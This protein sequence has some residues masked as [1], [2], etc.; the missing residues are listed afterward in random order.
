MSSTPSE[1]LKNTFGYPSFRPGQSDIIKTILNK[2]NILAIMPTGAGKS[3]CYQ[4]PAIINKKKTIVV[5]P[6][7]ALMDDQVNSLK[8]NK[9]CAERVHSNMTNDE[10]EEIFKKFYKGIVKILYM[11]PEALM[12]E[13]KIKEMQKLDIGLFV[14]DEAHCI[15]KWGP[16]FRK[17]YENLSKLKN[18]FPE[19]N[20]IA[21]TATADKATREDVMQ[22]LSNGNCKLFLQGFKRPNLS[23]SV[24]QKFNW[25]D[26]LIKFLKNKKGQSGIIYC[27]SR[28]NTE[29]V[30]EYL[31]S[32]KF[33]AI[34]YHAGQD[35]NTRKENQNSFM[36]DSGVI[37]AATIAFGM[38]ID[39]PDVRFVFHIS[40]PSNIESYYQEIGRAGRDGKP[41]DTMMIYGLDDLFQR[42]RFIEE[43]NSNEGHKKMEHRRLDALLAYCEASVCRQSALLAYFSDEMDKCKIC[44]NCM[45]PPIM[46]DGSIL[47]QKVLSAIYR[48]GQYFGSTYI[49]DVLRG[50]KSEKIIKNQH[51]KI[52]TFGVGKDYQ[53]EFWQSFIRQLISAN[54]I[55]IN[56]QKFGSYEITESGMNI[57][58]GKIKFKYKSIDLKNIILAKEYKKNDKIEIEEKQTPLLIKLKK[59]RLKL[60]KEQN[61]PAYVIFSDQTLLHMIE[62]KPKDIIE[63]NQIIGMG[64]NKI[65]KYG[66]IFINALK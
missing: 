32:Q 20:I 65:Q 9:V 46:E 55:R 11:S 41:S 47:A 10:S 48:T 6:L 56:I 53:K 14:I 62:K 15:S 25:K 39:K 35:Q 31:K 21:F 52:K 7:V 44:D 1:I 34:A 17:D 23:L 66:Q 45:T 4:I 13:G 5:S 54:H 42:R 50:S 38:G 16:G 60:A 33:K 26:Q 19:S 3:I 57:L 24:Y 30:A 36:T 2:N 51:N 22:K 37:I 8:Q 64:P 18:F 12:K 40:L 43:E 59:L 61:V 29:E 27:L 63:M 49:I 58:K 28:K